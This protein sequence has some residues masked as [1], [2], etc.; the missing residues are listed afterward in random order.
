VRPP[1]V[2]TRPARPSDAPT[3]ARTMH[4]GIETYR[5]FAP[6]A[7]APHAPPGHLEM[8]TERLRSRFTWALLAEV[9]GEPAAHTM[10]VPDWQPGGAAYL[11][12]L[13]VRPPW[14]GSGLAA[15]LHDRFLAEAAARGY[16]T[17]RLHTPAGH[18][19]ARRFYERRGWHASGPP[20]TWIDLPVIAYRRAVG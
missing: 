11:M 7:W 4:L 16:R 10:L 5:A 20:E 15:D 3:M 9:A 14:W 12:Q 1:A 6:G 8:L 2:T 13:F 19:R 17:A 18:A